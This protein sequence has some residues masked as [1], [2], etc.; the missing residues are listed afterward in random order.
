[1]KK[2]L[3]LFLFIVLVGCTSDSQ[4]EVNT[5]WDALVEK[6]NGTTMTFYGWG[7]DPEVNRIIDGIV[8]PNLKE[9]YNIDVKRIPMLPTDFID[10]M[11]TE[12]AVGKSSSVDVV[13]L[14]GYNFKLA[15]ELDLLMEDIPA[16]IPNTALL[17]LKSDSLMYDFNVPVDGRAIPIGKAQ[18]VML[19]NSS[20]VGEINSLDD[21]EKYVKENPQRFTYTDA[22]VDFVGS[23]FVRNV[24]INTIGLEEFNKLNS[25]M[26]EVEV[27]SIIKPALDYLNDIEP[28]LWNEGSTYPQTIG[29]L[30]NMYADKEVDFTMCYNPFCAYSPVSTGRFTEDTRTFVLGDYSIGNNH[31][32]SIAANSTNKAASIIFINEILSVEVQAAKYNPSGWGDFPILDFDKLNDEEKELFTNI[33]I[34]EHLLSFEKLNDLRVEEIDSDVTLM[35]DNLWVKYVATDQ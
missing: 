20:I 33:E 32:L 23:A 35:I 8:I 25:S 4:T 12:K 31:S 19:K 2:I 16:Y 26:T 17:D 10:I 22:R 13:W 29:I 34:S 15:K 6:A 27:Y 1:M 11:N 5:D 9:K 7:G 28:Y 14:N 24:V 30:N 18:F 21:L 3:L